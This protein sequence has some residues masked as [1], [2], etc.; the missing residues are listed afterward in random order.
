M[1]AESEQ[2][3]LPYVQREISRHGR[4]MWFFRKRRGGPRVRLPDVYGSAEFL[5]A[6][7][8]ALE[9]GADYRPAPIR[10]K[11]DPVRKQATEACLR[12]GLEMARVRAREK[13]LPF[14][15]NMD[16]ALAEVD[17]SD[18]RCPLTG[19]RFCTDNPSGSYMHPYAPSID[20]IDPKAGYTPWNCRVVSFAINAMLSD[21]GT[22][23]LE[24]VVRGYL[25]NKST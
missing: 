12:R 2:R 7:E 25:R 5:S 18:H 8:R 23:V 3:R 13:G 24:R 20:R 9:G 16:W 4:E 6:Y 10:N 21:W 15:L 17:A 11:L 1:R 22:V 19:I 14:T